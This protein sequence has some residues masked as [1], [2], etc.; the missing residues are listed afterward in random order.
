MGIFK[1]AFTSAD[2]L[3]DDQFKEYFYCDAL[4]D[5]TMLQRAA[6]KQGPARY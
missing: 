1:A 5:G 2:T 3:M 6:R 4:P